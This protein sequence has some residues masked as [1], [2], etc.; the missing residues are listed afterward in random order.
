[1]RHLLCVGAKLNS[2][3]G[4]G[5]ALY[6]LGEGG[7]EKRSPSLERV[8][9]VSACLR[10]VVV[11]GSWLGGLEVQCS[12]FAE[13]TRVFCSLLMCRLVLGLDGVI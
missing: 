6:G 12:L 13:L 9:F 5:V 11:T 3:S 7:L 1:M 2:P 8:G 4:E 10:L